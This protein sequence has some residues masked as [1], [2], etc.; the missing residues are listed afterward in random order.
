VSVAFSL[1]KHYIPRRQRWKPTTWSREEWNLALSKKTCAAGARVFNKGE[2][3]EGSQGHEGTYWRNAMEYTLLCSN[4]LEYTW[5]AP[6]MRRIFEMATGQN[7]ASPKL[8]MLW[9]QGS[10]ADWRSQPHLKRPPT[11]H[12]LPAVSCSNKLDREPSLSQLNVNLSYSSDNLICC[13]W[14]IANI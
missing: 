9:M 6:C 10:A 7:C 4:D 14:I 1:W 8:G 13:F 12:Q 2:H 11:L 5:I 3:R